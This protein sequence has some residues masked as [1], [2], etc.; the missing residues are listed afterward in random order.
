V[1]AYFKDG[2]NMTNQALSSF[3]S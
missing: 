3:K 2:A 1:S